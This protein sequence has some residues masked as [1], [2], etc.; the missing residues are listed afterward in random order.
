MLFVIAARIDYD[1]ALT[2]R[3]AESDPSTPS[4]LSRRECSGFN[5]KALWQCASHSGAFQAGSV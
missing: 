5:M 3:W 1:R 4:L 2:M